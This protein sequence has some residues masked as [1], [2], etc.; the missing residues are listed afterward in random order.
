ML[1][2]RYLIVGSTVRNEKGDKG[3]VVVFGRKWLHIVWENG[4]KSKHIIDGAGG[5]GPSVKDLFPVKA[6]P[7]WGY[8]R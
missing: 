1:N 3:T 5:F 4:K 6:A 7:G 2:W 8:K